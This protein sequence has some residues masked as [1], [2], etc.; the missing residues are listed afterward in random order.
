MGSGLSC[1]HNGPGKSWARPC[2][3]CYFL[4][5][6]VAVAG[7]GD[8]IRCQVGA[9]LVGQDHR[10]KST[11]YN[12]SAPGEGSCLAGG[13]DRCLS[14]VP[15]GTGYEGCIEVHA[16]ANA[17]LHAAWEDCQGSTLYITREPCRDCTKLIKAAG[18]ARV[19][20]PQGSHQLDKPWLR[21]A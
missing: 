4:T 16:E 6:A 5:I 1:T 7:R 9:V 19:V 10:I 18:V 20:W 12:G 14:D 2:W 15:S 11:G 21:A 13:C 8:C 3:D 17:L